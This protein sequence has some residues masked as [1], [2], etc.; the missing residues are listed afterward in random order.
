VH[1]DRKKAEHEPNDKAQD[2]DG[3]RNAAPVPGPG[4]ELVEVSAAGVNYADTHQS[5]F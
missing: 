1:A 2:S 5:L 4:E 3:G